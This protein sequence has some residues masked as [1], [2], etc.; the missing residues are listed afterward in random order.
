MQRYHTILILSILGGVLGLSHAYAEVRTFTDLFGRSIEA[1][2][3][4][5]EG[6]TAKI[7]RMQDLRVFELNLLN[8]IKEDRDYLKNWKASTDTPDVASEATQEPKTKK[9]GKWPRRVEVDDFDVEIVEEDSEKNRYIYR[10]PHFEFRCDVKLSRKVVRTF[11]EIFENT[12]EA[13]KQLPL[14]LNPSPPEKGYYI[15]KLYETVDSYLNDGG[16]VGSSGSYFRNSR[17]IKIPLSS[18]GVKKTSSS[19]TLKDSDRQRHTLIH[20][21]AHQVLHDWL[22]RFPVWQNEGIAEYIARVPYERGKFHFDEMELE[23]MARRDRGIRGAKELLTMSH[24]RWNTDLA[25]GITRSSG[26]YFSAWVYMYYF[27]HLE[28]EGDAQVFFDYVQSLA[29]GEDSATALQRLYQERSFEQ[30]EKDLIE[31]YEREGI[32]LSV[33]D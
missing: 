30:I 6:D 21:I 31:K 12:Y 29:Q 7:R 18:L 32:D 8:L 3:I 2:V 14:Q 9:P 16:M 17:E 4:S 22:Y 28:G 15:T 27:L 23:S 19:Y 1:E 24:Q 5:V 11:S 25:E 13:L 33:I 20:E 26:N 10:T